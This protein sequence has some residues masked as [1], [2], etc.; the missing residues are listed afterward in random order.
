VAFDYPIVLDLEDVPVLLVGGGVIASRKAEGLLAAGARVTVVA[1]LITPDL[2]G[3][4]AAT[5]V[6]R[7]DASDIAGHRLVLTATDDPTVNAAVA[8]DAGAAGV[9]ANSADDPQ[10]C[11]F[12]LPA[13]ARSG[14]IV[15]AVGTGGASP[16]LASRLRREIADTVLRHDVVAAAGDLA[17]QR[18]EMHQAGVSTESIDWTARVDDALARHRP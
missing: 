9:W 8:A 18:A 12:I 16:A 4:V 10:N 5:R 13:V 11:T 7:Y 1:P 15:V 6:K 14:P 2:A 17:A 3:R